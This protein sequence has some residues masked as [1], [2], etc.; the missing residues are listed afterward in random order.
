M[1]ENQ[2]GDTGLDI[3]DDL[4]SAVGISIRIVQALQVTRKHL[5]GIGLHR[6]GNPRNTAFLNLFHR[7]RSI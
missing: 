1:R 5:K 3:L 6:E 4:L 7:D 2:L